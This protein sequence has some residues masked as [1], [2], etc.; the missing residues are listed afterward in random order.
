MPSSIQSEGESAIWN[1]ND[2]DWFNTKKKLP[3][4]HLMLKMAWSNL[5]YKYVGFIIALKSLLR[6]NISCQKY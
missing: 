3:G 5:Q 4:F 2:F 1:L 6:Q